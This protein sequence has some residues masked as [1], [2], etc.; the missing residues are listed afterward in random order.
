MSIIFVGTPTFAVPSLR[1]LS[2]AGHEISAVVTQPDRPAGRHRT[3]RAPPVKLA[4]EELGL[5]VL[6]PESLR[7]ARAVAELRA[8]APEVIVVVAYGQIL[9]PEVLA[10]PTRGVL[11][12]HPSLLPRWRGASPIPAAI[13]EGDEQ[14]GVTIMLMDA[15]MDSGPILSQEA[16][17]IDVHDTSAS[18]SERLATAS[19]ELLGDTLPRWLSGELEP[20]PQDGSQATTSPL[21]RKEDGVID[22]RMSAPDIWRRVR[23][24]NPWPGAYTALDR[25]LLHIWRAWSLDVDSSAEAGIVGDIDEALKATLPADIAHVAAF[26]VQTGSGILVPL[27]VQR[28]GRR[29]LSA[30]EFRRGIS[31]LIGRRLGGEE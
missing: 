6:Q 23:A 10:I 3:P 8:L 13:L 1:R 16:F 24:Y 20:V 26:T 14:T 15:G 19:A 21:L 17:T 27:E 2:S 28:A 12:V 5:R 9:R 18:L 7:D 25:E 30:D 22:W 11:N 31:G 29:I 4:A